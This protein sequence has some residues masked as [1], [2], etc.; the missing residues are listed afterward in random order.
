MSTVFF[1]PA[2]LYTKIN[3]TWKCHPTDFGSLR[4][5]LCKIRKLNTVS[6][7]KKFKLSLIC[8]GKK[9]YSVM[10]PQ[11]IIKMTESKLLWTNGLYNNR[12]VILNEPMKLE[13]STRGFFFNG[14]NNPL[15]S[16][17]HL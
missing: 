17:Q 7:N 14:P 13:V 3:V 2:A 8:G 10:S 1:N 12:R 6:E 9:N 15:T 16:K 11:Q 5:E 4:G